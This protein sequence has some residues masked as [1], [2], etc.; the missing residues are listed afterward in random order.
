MFLGQYEHTID[1]KGRMT[2][3]AR[4]R[5]QVEGGAFITRELAKTSWCS[6]LPTLLAFTTMSTRWH[7]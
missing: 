1:E 6:P 3:P 4:Y 2:I 5:E 7:N